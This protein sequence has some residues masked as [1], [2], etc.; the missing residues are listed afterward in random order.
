VTG[1][2][3][4]LPYFGKVWPL[5]SDKLVFKAFVREQGL[6]TPPWWT[7]PDNGVTD[8]HRQ[9]E[10]RFVRVAASAAR[11]APW[12]AARRRRRCAKASSTS[13]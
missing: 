2:C 3:G 8:F 12:T 7:S 9:G 4:W 13:A 11:S 10:E 5:S 6:R 1:F